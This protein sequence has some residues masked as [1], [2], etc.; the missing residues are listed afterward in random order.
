[1]ERAQLMAQEKDLAFLGGVGSARS[2][3][4][5]KSLANIA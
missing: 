3:I 1:L 2:T 5:A 4:Q